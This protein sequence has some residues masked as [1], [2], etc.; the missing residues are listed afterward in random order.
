MSYRKK[1]VQHKIGRIKDK[2]PILAKPWIWIALLVAVIFVAG[3]YFALFYNGLWVKDII[4]SGNQRVSTQEIYDFVS[5][6]TITGLVKL[7][8]INITTKSILFVNKENINK[9]V[10]EK[11][12]IIEKINLRKDYPQTLVLGV[13]ERKPIGVYCDKDNKCYLIDQN[14]IVFEAVAGTQ[15]NIT[16]V[17]QATESG[18]VF[19]GEEVVSRN[20]ID[21]I[22]KIQK[23][24]KEK[25]SINLD[26]ALIT[27]PVR[28]NIKT[29]EKW[30]IYFDIEGNYNIDSQITKLNVLL[31]GS[32]SGESR[33]N[34]RYIDLRPKDRAIICDNDVCGG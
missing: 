1:H 11:F 21:A 23:N 4:I 24:L 18:Q 6:K 25:F 7:G 5:K 15:E 12:P 2:E 19:T 32:L 28:L 20:I 3:L 34:L 17:R 31:D 26:E 14:G 27:S 13:E 33:N 30:Q 16:T 8:P 29:G 9:D 22:Y 10:L